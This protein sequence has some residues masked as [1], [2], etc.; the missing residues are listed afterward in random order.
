VANVERD[1]DD[2]G[3]IRTGE[4]RA[5]RSG[6]R[7]HL[8]VLFCA[9]VEF[10][11][12]REAARSSEWWEIVGNY[13]CAA[14]QLIERFGGHIA[15]CLDDGVMPFSAGRKRTR[16]MQSVGPRPDCSIEPL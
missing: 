16:T 5:A 7:H 6:E 1:F 14:A 3:P 11:Q 2:G 10:D 8:T 15:Q 12:H 13:H 9:L 4:P